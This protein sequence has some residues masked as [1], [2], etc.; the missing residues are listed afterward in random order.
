MDDWE[1]NRSSL[2]SYCQRCL[3][4]VRE[5]SRYLLEEFSQD[6]KGDIKN[7]EQVTKEV[8]AQYTWEAFQRSDRYS[9]HSTTVSNRF[10]SMKHKIASLKIEQ[11]QA[12]KIVSECLNL[13]QDILSGEFSSNV[14]TTYESDL[15]IIKQKLSKAMNV[16]SLRD[17][18]G[19]MET[20]VD[21]LQQIATLHRHAKTIDLSGVSE[22]K[23]VIRSPI[24]DN[25][26]KIDIIKKEIDRF[27]HLILKMDNTA[28]ESLKK[29]LKGLD[30]ETNEQRINLVRDQVKL[31]Y[32]KIKEDLALML[33][34]KEMLGAIS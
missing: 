17:K 32:G 2:D 10:L 4:E 16:H 13:S 34:C 33:A 23:A 14:L 12:S 7:L 18:R 27:V 28:N 21:E 15:E 26:A 25:S 22:E 20:L 9:E 29:L 24:K 31:T 19:A 3:K 5:E 11:D 1:D 30:K 8:M 6:I